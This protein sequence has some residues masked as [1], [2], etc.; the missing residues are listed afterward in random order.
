MTG[1]VHAYLCCAYCCGFQCSNS[2]TFLPAGSRFGTLRSDIRRHFSPVPAVSLVLILL[3]TMG[4]FAVAGRADTVSGAEGCSGRPFRH[5]QVPYP[6]A[7]WGGGPDETQLQ[8]LSER[9]PLSLTLSLPA[10]KGNAVVPEVFP[11]VPAGSLAGA[12]VT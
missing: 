8:V 3:G 7:L 10:G 2:Q 6:H 1:L 11:S 12:G 9:L 4:F 5:G